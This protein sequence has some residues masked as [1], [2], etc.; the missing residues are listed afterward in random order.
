MAFTGR[1]RTERVLEK[2]KKRQEWVIALA[3]NENE[4]VIASQRPW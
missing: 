2:L 3:A 4:F 1:A